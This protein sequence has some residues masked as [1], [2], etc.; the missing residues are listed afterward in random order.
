MTHKEVVREE[1]KEPTKQARPKEIAHDETPA[2]IT[3]HKY[4]PRDEWW[5][6]CKY[7]PLAEAAHAESELRY[8]GDDMSDD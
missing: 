5:S 4:A 2:L 3:D 7:C 8:V 1:T 6:L